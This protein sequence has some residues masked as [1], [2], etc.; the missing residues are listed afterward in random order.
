MSV[1]S[2]SEN[3]RRVA[4][5]AIISPFASAVS[6]SVGRTRSRVAV[7]DRIAKS[8]AIRLLKDLTHGCLTLIDDDSIHSFGRTGDEMAATVEIRDPRA[9]RKL[10]F[11]GSL[12]VAE[13]FMS[14]WWTTDDLTAVMRIM[15]RNSD[16][17]L[18]AEKGF[19]R[20]TQSLLSVLNTLRLNTLGGSRRNIAAHYDLSDEFFSVWLDPTMTYSA[21]VFDSPTS[22]MEEASRSKYDRICRKLDLSHRDHVVEIGSG[23]GGFAVYAARQFG[24]RVTTTTISRRQ[25]EYT[26]QRVREAGLDGQVNVVCRDYREM[27]G[28]FDKLVSIEMIEAVGH[29]YLD[30]YF[31]KCCELLKPNGMMLLQAITIPDQHYERYRRSVE[32]TQRYIFPG[33]LLP[34]FSSIGA[35]LR[36]VTDFRL[37]HLEDIGPHYAE[38]LARWRVRFLERLDD[39]RR[40]GFDERFIRMW[41]YY[42]AYC[43]GGF[44]ERYIGTS[45]ILLTKPDCRRESIVPQLDT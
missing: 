38:T 21:G 16:V 10:L 28:N 12:G 44:R 4:D 9:Y 32:F 33:G 7:I 31:R 39:V 20:V 18:R 29:K 27:T 23:W 19:V 13:A 42:L 6:E 2:A 22:T 24:C 17:L 45:Q 1:V 41:H 26:K 30:A 25:F 15:A 3:A 5:H 34:S 36:R 43:E 37:F 11:G 40:L 35:S 14:G 8:C